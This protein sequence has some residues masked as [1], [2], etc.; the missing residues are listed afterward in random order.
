MP[1]L[2]K[3]QAFS[4]SPT[5]RHY[6]QIVNKNNNPCKNTGRYIIFAMQ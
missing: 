3:G 1:V 6:I 4:V 2:F 5:H